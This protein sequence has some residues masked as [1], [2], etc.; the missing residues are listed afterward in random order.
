MRSFFRKVHPDFFHNLPE[1]RKV[2]EESLQQ[3]NSLIGMSLDAAVDAFQHNKRPIELRFY[4]K[5][6]NN[7]KEIKVT[8]TIPSLQISSTITRENSSS[9]Y[10]RFLDA[11]M[12]ELYQQSKVPIAPNHVSLFKSMS[13]EDG[14]KSTED[15]RRMTEEERLRRKAT[16]GASGRQ[17]EV[18]WQM[19]E[20]DFVVKGEV[21]A[22]KT[23]SPSDLLKAR[24]QILF[25]F[26]KRFMLFSDELTEFEKDV[27]VIHLEEN[28]HK[29]SYPSWHSIPIFLMPPESDPATCPIKGVVP[30]PSLFNPSSFS[31]Y[32]SSNLSSILSQRK[33]FEQTVQSIHT[34]T[35]RLQSDIE[36]N[37]LT[38]LM[39]YSELRS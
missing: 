20:D 17:N 22:E 4:V 19:A 21:M 35:A 11:V 29:L 37:I 1:M 26:Q 18:Q 9:R 12:F 27:G 28:L 14:R 38:I 36:R 2:N 31:K 33:S 5:E 34:V 32:L 16:K 39:S 25:S 7:Y 15:E 6:G 10:Q 24:C 3:L 8:A 13:E 30:V 23:M